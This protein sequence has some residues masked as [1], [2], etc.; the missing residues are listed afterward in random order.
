MRIGILFGVA[1]ATAIYTLITIFGEYHGM[2][3][4]WFAL[5]WL[6]WPA[7]PG[8]VLAYTVPAVTTQSLA[9]VSAL[10]LLNGLLYGSMLLAWRRA[11]T[12]PG[13]RR[14]WLAVVIGW[15]VFVIGRAVC[16]AW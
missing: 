15:I 13:M 8:L 14:L 2:F 5:C 4:V 12:N 11:G 1:A 9:V 10:V 16:E 3:N 6:L 7:L